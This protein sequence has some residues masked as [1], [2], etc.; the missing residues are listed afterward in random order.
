MAETTNPTKKVRLLHID[1][2]STDGVHYNET[3]RLDEGDEFFELPDRW[4]L[5]KKTENGHIQVRDI[6]VAHT[7][8]F[9]RRNEVVEITP[10]YVPK[11]HREKT[12]PAPR[13]VG[14]VSVN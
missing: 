7:F 10:L 1:A 4:Q 14:R 8:F 3:L 6:Y 5:K 11:E 9:G 2:M 12:E 13:K